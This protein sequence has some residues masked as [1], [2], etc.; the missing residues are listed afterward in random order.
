MPEPPF[1]LRFEFTQTHAAAAL[2]ELTMIDKR[3]LDAGARRLWVAI[4]GMML[5]VG[6]VLASF[7]NLAIG[8]AVIALGFILWFLVPWPAVRAPSRSEIARLA[9]R[10][11]LA[12]PRGMNSLHFGR[13]GVELHDGREA[14]NWSW[15]GIYRLVVGD[16][17]LVLMRLDR[18]FIVVPKAA[19]ESDDRER[20]FR[21]YVRKQISRHGARWTHDAVHASGLH[22]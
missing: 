1:H 3:E 17:M 21:T 18:S 19:L 14:R 9:N 13:R 15:S 10:S 16:D 4:V 20:R 11:Q 5:F 12:N 6:I 7:V 8:L 22:H 2:R